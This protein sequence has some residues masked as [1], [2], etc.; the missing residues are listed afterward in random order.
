MHQKMVSAD[1]KSCL[2]RH[3]TEGPTFPDAVL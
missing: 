1:G 3:F 2:V